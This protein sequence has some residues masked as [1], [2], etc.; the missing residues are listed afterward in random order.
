M[1]KKPKASKKKP[2][3]PKKRRKAVAKKKKSQDVYKWVTIALAVVVIAVTLLS[4]RTEEATPAV[5]TTTIVLTEGVKPGDEVSMNYIA[6]FTNGT[7][8]DTSY[9]DIARRENILIDVRQYEPLT[10]TVGSGQMIP[11]VEV[12]IIGM[13]EGEKKTILVQPESAYGLYD[14]TR[15]QEVNRSYY[16]TRVDTIPLMDFEVTVGI[17]SENTT[18][19]SPNIPWPM[20]IINSSVDV[21]Y[22]RYDPEVNSTI[23]TLLGNATVEKV[24]DTEILLRESPIMGATIVT[25]VGQAI[26]LDFD[27]ET[28]TLDF[29][30]PLAGKTLEFTITVDGI[31]RS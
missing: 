7:V 30:H 29:N 14:P 17:P 4:F 12:E 16:V 2:S 18:M 27:N 25:G 10:F 13:K 3:T 11:G 19:N 9:G 15:I 1:E 23:M 26:V 24:T 28:I 22:L 6:R 8:F 31:A 20:F 21:V 5:T